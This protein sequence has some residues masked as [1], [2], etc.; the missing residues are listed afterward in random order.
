MDGDSSDTEPTRRNCALI[1]K[2]PTY[3]IRKGGTGMFFC[4]LFDS[5]IYSDKEF[6]SR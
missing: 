2:Y 6:F 1:I 3:L 4:A 5:T